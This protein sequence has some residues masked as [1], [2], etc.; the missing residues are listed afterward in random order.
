MLWG[1][2]GD[3]M[4]LMRLGRVSAL[5]FAA[6]VFD[7]GCRSPATHPDRPQPTIPAAATP[8]TSQPLRPGTDIRS[9]LRRQPDGSVWYQ[10]NRGTGL[11]RTGLSFY[12]YPPLLRASSGDRLVIGRNAVLGDLCKD[13]VPRQMRRFSSGGEGLNAYGVADTRNTYSI[14]QYA[15][16]GWVNRYFLGTDV[17][18]PNALLSIC[19][20][21]NYLHTRF[22][23]LPADLTQFPFYP[24]Y[25]A[26]LGS[27]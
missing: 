13:F 3:P 1:E 11:G 18:S 24:R 10:E 12:D 20:G 21:G 9:S 25:Q 8:P 14:I 4:D 7:A 17:T 2:P 6:G 15:E 16:D 22:K 23:R 19:R 26:A 27:P 5:S